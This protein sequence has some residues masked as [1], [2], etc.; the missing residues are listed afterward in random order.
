MMFVTQTEDA[1]VRRHRDH[2]SSHNTMRSAAS[3]FQTAAAGADTGI[4]DQP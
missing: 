3:Y 2:S 4:R 1:Y